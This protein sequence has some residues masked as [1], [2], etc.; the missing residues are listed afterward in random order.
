MREREIESEERERGREEQGTEITMMT[1]SLLTLFTFLSLSL[2]CLHSLCS[3]GLL[4]L[5]NLPLSPP[6]TLWLNRIALQKAVLYYY[7]GKRVVERETESETG[8][9]RERERE[10]VNQARSH[11]ERKKINADVCQRW[12]SLSLLPSD[13]TLS[14][15]RERERRWELTKNRERVQIKQTR[16][17]VME[18]R[19]WSE[20]LD[21]LHLFFPSLSLPSFISSILVISKNYLLNPESMRS[22]WWWWWS[23]IRIFSSFSLSRLSSFVLSLLSS[24]ILSFLSAIIIKSITNSN[25]GERE[26]WILFVQFSS[27]FKL[28]PRGSYSKKLHSFFLLFLSFFCFSKREREKGREDFF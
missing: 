17:K 8:R 23:P 13:R 4:L 24:S 26:R 22:V 6:L 19:K 15:Q 16:I 9:D 28:S 11:V 20:T 27:S 12:L 5:T 10:R 25:G 2:T 14:H 3:V 21:C 1:R 18:W 7:I